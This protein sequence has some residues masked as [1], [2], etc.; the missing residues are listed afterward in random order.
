MRI[1]STATVASLAVMASLALAACGSGSSGGSS[2]GGAVNGAGK[3][4]DVLVNVNTNYPEQQKQWFTDTAKKFKDQTGADLKFETFTS[5]NDELTRIQTSVVSGQGP[6]VYSLG[7]T[8]TPTAYATN[9]FVTLSDDDWKKVGGKDRF[10]QAALG[11][12]GPDKDHLAGIPFVSRPFIMAYNKDLLKAAGIDKPA[13]TWDGLL[14]Q[15]KKLTDPAKGQYGMAVA[16]KDNFDPWKYIWAMSVQA[17]NPLVDGKTAK[18]DD[19]TVQKAYQTY[20]GWLTKD[21]VVNPAAVGWSNSQALADFA[22]G[23]SAYF[24]MTTTTSL[25]TLEKSAIKDKFEYSLMPTVAPGETSSKSDQPAA[26]I[27]SGDNLVVADYSKNKDLA[28]AYVNLVTSKDEQLNYQKTF[29][30]LP[31][32]ADALASL[33]SAPHMAASTQSAKESKATP[34]TGAW[35]DIQLAL[36]NVTVQSLPDLASGNVSDAALSQRIKDA[37]TKSQQSLDR[38]K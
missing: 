38:A 23:K 16:Y 28:F 26:S 17:G 36:L 13:T 9:A 25:P 19:P 5:A 35:G 8:F 30:D 34:F 4:L 11:I 14:D 3:T 7:T 1:R 24:L 6:D 29:G 32:N 33:G 22:S 31:A 37:Q 15:A 21:K 18:L 2:S 27:L 10:N 12:S 20:F